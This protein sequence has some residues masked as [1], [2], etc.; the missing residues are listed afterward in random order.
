[1]TPVTE[2]LA[3]L[4][5]RLAAERGPFVLFALL[6]RPQLSSVVST[7]DPGVLGRWDLVVSA[8]WL[9][10]DRKSEL[11]YLTSQLK[12]ETGPT[13]LTQLSRVVILAPDDPFVRAVT[14]TF[15]TE[16]APLEVRNTSL[17]GIQIDRAVIITARP[18]P[19]EKV[20]ARR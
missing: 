10:A 18:K 8:E 1:M 7:S 16:H 9:N 11:D 17:F 5:Q 13:V 6:L 14:K 20:V 3:R 4:E 15:S 12:V 2:V 19:D